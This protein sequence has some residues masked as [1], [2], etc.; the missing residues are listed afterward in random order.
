MKI[1]RLI[2]FLCLIFALAAI[3]GC[4]GKKQQ[5]ASLPADTKLQTSIDLPQ[6]FE[7]EK[8]SKLG[9]ISEPGELIAL[10]KKEN[11]ILSPHAIVEEK[12]PQVEKELPYC[13]EEEPSIEFHFEN[14]DL[15][16]LINQISELFD[17]T[18]VADDSITPMLQG[19]KTVKGN[20]ISFKTQRPL[21]KKEAWDL[22]VTFLDIAG[23]A[24]I[25]EANPKLK[26]IVTIDLAKKSPLRAFIGV[27]PSELPNS[28]EMVRYVYFVENAALETIAKIANDLRSPSSSLAILQEMKA[29][30]ITD[31]S[32]NIKSL[33]NIVKELDK[34]VMPQAMSVLKLRK[35]DAKEVKA[36]YDSL[37]QV[38]EKSMAQQRFFPG[39]R[40][41]PSAYFSDNVAV[42]A[43]PRTNSL[44]LLGPQDSI[45]RIEDF[46][47]QSVDVDLTQP[48]SPLHVLPL[49]YADAKTIADI[50]NTVTRFGEGSEAGRTGGVRGGDKYMKPIT[51]TPEFETNRLIIKGDYEDFL[52]AKEIISELDAPQPQV[53]IEVLLLSVALND[54]RQLGAQIRSR[55]PGSEGLAGTNVKFQTSGLFGTGQI[56]TDPNGNGVNRL[57][58]NLLNLVSSGIA[59]GNTIISLGD[60]LNV[61]AIIQALETASNVQVL[62]NPFL[63]ATNKA[64]AVVSLGEVRR[65]T[66]GTIVGGSNTQTNTYGDAP[67]ELKVEIQPQINSD[68]M[69]VLEI[70]VKLSQFV[71]AA[72]PDNAVRTTREI[73]TKTIVTNKEVIALGGLIQTNIE[74]LVTKVPVL[75][76]MPLLGWLFKN[77]TK[78]ASKSNLLILISSRII[79]PQGGEAIT[80][81]TNDHLTDYTDTVNEMYYPNERRDPINRWFFRS[82]DLNERATDEFIFRRQKDALEGTTLQ[83]DVVTPIVAQAPKAPQKTIVASNKKSKGSPLMTALGNEKGVTA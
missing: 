39:R 34:S 49:R 29:L 15:E 5:K 37:A 23:F 14:A 60:S 48:Y 35:A 59:A 20:K 41:P 8:L 72:N 2:I 55:V 32:Y 77:K 73:K 30:I 57:L 80:S 78:I 82:K 10:E 25:S 58:G 26:R 11:E 67:A 70:V 24:V 83:K 7:D 69:I 66:T 65:V 1:E 71:G 81:F 75:G 31:K 62:A 4:G 40:T 45:K 9:I 33:M 6:Q 12:S 28:D 19:A 27:P 42:F 63:I 36:L 76:D 38:D 51:F 22:F 46:I 21:T 56:V 68:G 61:W 79:E 18:F 50:M 53:A 47:T 52:R 17:L 3:P 43:E 54:K 13:P 74:N 64:K 44:I 16:M